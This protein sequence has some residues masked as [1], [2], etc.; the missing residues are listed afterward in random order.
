MHL[1]FLNKNKITIYVLLSI[2]NK[3]PGTYVI[4]STLIVEKKGNKSRIDKD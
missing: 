1:L 2:L 3:I 4:K